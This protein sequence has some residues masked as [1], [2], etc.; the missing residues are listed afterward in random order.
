MS[1]QLKDK[2]LKTEI[3]IFGIRGIVYNNSIFNSYFKDRS[4]K[5]GPRLNEMYTTLGDVVVN[6]NI[7]EFSVFTELVWNGYKVLNFKGYPSV[8]KMKK[9]EDLHFELREPEYS[10]P[11][12]NSQRYTMCDINF[13]YFLD[14]QEMIY[15]WNMND[16][17]NWEK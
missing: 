1:I 14:E 15:D 13:R 4:L 6:V 7:D 3:S 16:Q 10:G 2:V 9:I 11:L 8:S 17:F 12:K 5:L